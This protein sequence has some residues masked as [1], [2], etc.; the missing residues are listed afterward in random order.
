MW[1]LGIGEDVGTCLILFYFSYLQSPIILENLN[2][3]EMLHRGLQKR[4][5]T[6]SKVNFRKV[7]VN[8]C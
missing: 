3:K 4:E 1:H 8:F 6:G 5:D 7:W 2:K